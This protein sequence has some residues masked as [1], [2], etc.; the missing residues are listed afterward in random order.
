L[1][2]LEVSKASE[3]WGEIDPPG[4][5]SI[6][7]RAYMISAVSE[8][9]GIVE[10]A[11]ASQDCEHT[12]QVLRD[13]GVRIIVSGD[14]VKIA[15]TPF[16]SPNRPLYCGNSGTTMRLMSGLLA[17]A[18]VSATLTGDSSLSQRPMGR[19]V[20]PLLQM[21]ARIEG[22][23]PPIKIDP[24]RLSG[25]SY[26]TPVPS[27]QIKSAVLLA[28]LFAEGKTT[29]N[30]TVL[31]RDHTERMLAAAEC[32]LHRDGLTVSI[33]QGMPKR[34]R[35]R[36]PADISSA[37]FFLVAGALLGGPVT[38]K[39]VGINPARTGVLDI[40]RAVG[41]TVETTPPRQQQGEPVADLLVESARGLMAFEI[42][43][44]E[45]PRLI[46]EIPVLAIMATQCE[47]TSKITGAKELRVKE[48]DRIES[49]A[50]GLKAMGANVETFG[51]GLAITGPTALRGARI[52]AK[53]DHRIGMAFAVAG[54]IADG[55]T[56]IDGA[57]TIATSF[58]HFESE[59]RRMANA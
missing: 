36:V 14:A 5:K 30:E 55:T 29:V 13:L 4:D 15:G 41:A 58:P 50:S 49:I 42:G 1:A 39:V 53:K 37:S 34:V 12:L 10:G 33:E 54:L 3:F 43:A 2:R 21:G 52:D 26:T 17:G 32:R 38:A 18:G 44:H 20:A 9:G 47:G 7:H 56:T 16:R 11:L 46:D 28:G 51:D 22:D 19:I 25:I 8:E 45:I 35:M 48:S 27:A 59:L 57:E 31:S 24:A 40:L 23:S 6:T